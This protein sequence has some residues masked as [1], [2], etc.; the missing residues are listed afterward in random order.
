MRC[1]LPETQAM[2]KERAI[3]AIVGIAQC[4]ESRDGEDVLQM[5][6]RRYNNKDVF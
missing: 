2:M 4:F 3:I 6:L 1:E 5:A